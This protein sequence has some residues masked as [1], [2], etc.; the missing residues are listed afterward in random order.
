[1]KTSEI[2]RTARLSKRWSQA[3]LA[4]QIG[5]ARPRVTEWE[6]DKVEP[7]ASILLEILRVT[8][9]EMPKS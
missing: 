3:E 5:V 9:Y 1:M 4:K 7:R 6:N 2:I 8:G